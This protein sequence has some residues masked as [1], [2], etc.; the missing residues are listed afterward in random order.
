MHAQEI[1]LRADKK[2]PRMKFA[3]VTDKTPISNYYID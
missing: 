3:N 2:I 1:A